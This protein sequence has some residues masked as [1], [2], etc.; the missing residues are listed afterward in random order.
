MTKF[1]MLQK[2]Q[3]AAWVTISMHKTKRAGLTEYLNNWERD[4]SR[5][6]LLEV[7]PKLIVES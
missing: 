3:G 7:T 6:R 4:Y 5:I 2:K 1:Y